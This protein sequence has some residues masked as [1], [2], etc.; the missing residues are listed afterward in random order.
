[1]PSHT[2]EFGVGVSMSTGINQFSG[3]L[4]GLAVF[5]HALTP[6]EVAEVCGWGLGPL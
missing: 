3:L 5:Q 1:M 4:G 6:V 2:A